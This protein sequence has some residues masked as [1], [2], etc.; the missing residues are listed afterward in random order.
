MILLDTQVLLWLR[1]GSSRLGQN[2][3]RQIERAWQSDEVGVSAISFWEVAMLK[4][5][6]GYGSARM[7]ANGAANS[8]SRG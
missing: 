3:R 7:S 8:W 1:L 2:A 4:D 5:K 6:G